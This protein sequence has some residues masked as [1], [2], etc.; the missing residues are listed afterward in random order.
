MTT[1]LPLVLLVLATTGLGMMVLLGFAY[2]DWFS[3]RRIL[4]EAK[5]DAARTA[6]ATAVPQP[7]AAAQVKEETFLKAA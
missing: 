7:V 4:D 5:K 3:Y 6:A 1:T 2:D